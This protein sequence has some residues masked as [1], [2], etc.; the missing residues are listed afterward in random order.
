MSFSNTYHSSSQFGSWA[1][2]F[3][4]V[5]CNSIVRCFKKVHFFSKNKKIA[6][7]RSLFLQRIKKKAPFS[8]KEKKGPF[9][10]K[11][12][13]SLFVKRDKSV[14][15]S[16][17]GWKGSFFSKRSLFTKKCQKGPFFLKCN[18]KAF[19]SL[20]NNIFQYEPQY[21]QLGSKRSLFVKKVSFFLKKCLKG[22]FFLK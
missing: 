17:K 10:C 13:R 20:S 8:S 12:K 11:V 4:F 18:K 6:L 1:F 5:T 2:S 16:Q 15:F 19:Q 22:P 3:L 7:L 14:L 21:I 9:L